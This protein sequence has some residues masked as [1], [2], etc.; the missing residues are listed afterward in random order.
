M[1]ENK[2]YPPELSEFHIGFEYEVQNKENGQWEKFDMGIID[3]SDEYRKEIED[4]LTR[5]K[6]LDKSDI[7]SFGFNKTEWKST[8]IYKKD[9]YLLSWFDNEAISIDEFLTEIP[10]QIFRGFIKNKSELKFILKRIGITE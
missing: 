8:A 1:E 6:Y 3:W 7:E 10:H 9:H 4:G 2:Y 5:V